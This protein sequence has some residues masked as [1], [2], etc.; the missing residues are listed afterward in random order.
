MAGG[1]SA[2]ASLV[3]GDLVATFPAGDETAWH[4]LVETAL[5]GRSFDKVLRTKTRDGFTVGPLYGQREMS[6]AR[7]ARL[8]AGPWTISQRVDHPDPEAAAGFALADLE[9]G[10]DGLTLVSK[11]AASAGGFG[12][13]LNAASLAAVFAD[14]LP[15]IIRLRIDAPADGMSVLKA[16]ADIAESKSLSLS[17]LTVDPGF[18]PSSVLANGLAE[19]LS[20]AAHGQA[21]KDILALGF[22]G[23]IGSADG[24]IAGDAGATDSQ[25]L[26]LVLAGLLAHL[27]AAE[28]AGLDVEEVA[29]RLEA[30]ITAGPDTF[31][32]LTK[33]RVMRMLFARLLDASGIS[34]QPLRIHAETAWAHVSGADPYVNMLRATSAV[35]GAGLGGA[36]SIL[37]QPL[38]AA[39]GLA[40]GF[41]RR[42]ARNIQLVLIE[43]SFLHKVADP[44]AGSGY[45]EQRSAALAEA[46]WSVFQQVESEGGI[47]PALQS[48]L[49]AD[50]VAQSRAAFEAELACRMSPLTGVTEYAASKD[51]LPDVLPIA[52]TERDQRNGILPRM[53]WSEPF[54]ALRARSLSLRQGSD[55]PAVFLATLGTLPEFNARATFAGNTYAIAG[56][57]S[58]TGKGGTDIAA[59]VSEAKSSQARLVCLC[60]SDEAY[61]AHGPQ[62]AVALREA[63]LQD[64]HMAGK[65]DEAMQAA[66]VTTGPSLRGDVLSLL[67][68]TLEALGA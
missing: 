42:M 43:E 21:L 30:I 22:G 64:L 61:A 66:G 23:T 68:E 3:E 11:K 7:A 27:K 46:A 5:K 38:T 12:L 18:D 4:A 44:G 24:R 13:D 45:F 40:D 52:P 50:M 54:E 53:R 41:A 10:T 36:D 20:P 28:E 51:A 29:G 63:G 55:T 60:T 8:A 2:V 48:G 16:M 49:V 14:I 26:G 25:E 56:L 6:K 59:V 9:G 19:A 37:V 32:S 39:L 62:L 58:A 17:Q 31:A 35:A 15:D 65:P 34:D 47:T 57:T 33:T 1:E 67:N